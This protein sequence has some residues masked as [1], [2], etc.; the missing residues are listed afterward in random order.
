MKNNKYLIDY[1]RKTISDEKKYITNL[2]S[3]EYKNK[4]MPNSWRTTINDVKLQYF[5][6]RLLETNFFAGFDEELVKKVVNK[7]RA[8][9]IRVDETVKTI[10][11]HGKLSPATFLNIKTVCEK[12]L[13]RR[14]YDEKYANMIYD[15]L[16]EAI[17]ECDKDK[18]EK[19]RETFCSGLDEI[20]NIILEKL[21]GEKV[22]KNEENED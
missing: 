7:V 9:G 11:Q 1:I 13:E 21:L 16:D 14:N 8:I 6:D 10:K 17:D 4:D 20:A 5:I 3:K 18:E 2:P 22:S 19:I 12:V 15:L